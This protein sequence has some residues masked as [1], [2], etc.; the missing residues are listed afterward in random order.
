MLT[1][2]ILVSRVISPVN[3]VVLSA[4]DPDQTRHRSPHTPAG[5]PEIVLR[6]LGSGFEMPSHDRHARYEDQSSEFYSRVFE[7]ASTDLQDPQNP[8]Y[9]STASS[10]LRNQTDVAAASTSRALFLS[11][12]GSCL[13]WLLGRCK[14]HE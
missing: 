14:I 6:V 3:V 8:G 13:Q 4:G 7:T 1:Y 9:E 11:H 5:R 10:N 2:I 12:N